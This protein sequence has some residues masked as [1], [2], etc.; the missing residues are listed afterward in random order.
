MPQICK[1]SSKSELNGYNAIY[2]TLTYL[3]MAKMKETFLLLIWGVNKRTNKQGGTK[4]LLLVTHIHNLL[5]FHFLFVR[6][7]SVRTS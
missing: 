5:N 2:I 4:L 1:S 7:S 6:E 3:D